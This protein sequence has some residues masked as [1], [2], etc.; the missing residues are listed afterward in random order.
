MMVHRPVRHHWL[1][2]KTKC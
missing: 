2:T 1:Q